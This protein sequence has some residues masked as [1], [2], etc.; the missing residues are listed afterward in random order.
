[1]GSQNKNS[2]S[3]P[4][5]ERYASQKMSAVFSP[6]FK[7]ST[8]RKLWVALAEGQQELGL[9]I[10][11][12]QIEE[13]R[14]FVDDIDFELAATYEKE[15]R[16]DVM[17]HVHTFGSQCPKAKPII[18]LGATSAYVGDNTDLIQLKK[19]TEITLS[20]LSTLIA[21]LRNF[22]WENRSVATLGFTHFQPAQLTTVGKRASLWLYDLLMDFEAL[23]TFHS[24]LRFRG[25]KGT[26]GTQASFLSLFEGNHQ[27]VKDLD[28]SVCSKMNFEKVL[29]VTGQ[30]YTRKID[31]QITS[32]LSG[33]AQSLH[34]IANDIRLLQ[35]LKEIEEPFETKQIGSSAMA[36]KRNPMRSERLTAL[37][38]FIMSN[39]LSP[40]MTAAEQWFERTLDDSANKRLTIPETFLGADAA[41]IIGEN[42]CNGLVVYPKVIEKHINA[43]LPFMATENIIMAAVK[44]GAD[45]QEIHERIRIHSMEAAKEVKL[46]G[47]E[48][49]LLERVASDPKF[50]MS[51]E[52]LLS[53]LKVS[54]FIGR[55]PEQVEEFLRESVDPLIKKADK[56]ANTQK[57]DL[58]V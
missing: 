33:L 37:C 20:R 15:T 1:M 22:A 36:Y 9:P 21:T 17:A 40:A 32:I 38:R 7:F 46:K 5:L 24:S 18:H 45:R 53:L 47:K 34:K 14:A 48:N 31:S 30:T 10:S 42:V 11:D 2:Y 52:D 13:M 57:E 50:S 54:D 12:E 26:T 29:P 4:L 16:H 19:A 44:K 51:K 3:N 43:E 49:D 39:S 28:S 55:A 41:L 6:Q 56:F 27:K 8:W 25:V 35:N 23:E 58:S